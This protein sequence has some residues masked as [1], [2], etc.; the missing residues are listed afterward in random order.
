MV[1][2]KRYFRGIRKPF[3]SK[4]SFRV[5]LIFA[6]PLILLLLVH[7]FWLTQVEVRGDRPDL[8]L[9]SGDRILV[10]RTTYGVKLP[11]EHRWGYHRL[12]YG[13]PERGDMVV[14]E[15]PGGSGQVFIG[16]IDGLPGDT[17]W[18]EEDPAAYMIVPAGMY[19]ADGTLFP[20]RCLIGTPVCISYSV[21]SSKPFYQ[22]LRS[23]RLFSSLE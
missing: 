6:L 15:D 22:M 16:R 5:V 19:G 7:T 12:G 3:I 21:D 23:G 17:L 8:E 4:G 13:Q 18:F 9:L 10:N 14:Y 11:F 2:I 1:T 20:V